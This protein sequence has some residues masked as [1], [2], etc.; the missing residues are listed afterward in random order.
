MLLACYLYENR[1]LFNV[2]PKYCAHLQLLV[3]VLVQ[4]QQRMRDSLP[5]QEP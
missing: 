2:L 5:L 1:M 3:L 4:V